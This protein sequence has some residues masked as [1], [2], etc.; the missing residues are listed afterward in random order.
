MLTIKGVEANNVILAIS[1]Y[2]IRNI[3][4]EEFYGRINKSA[5]IYCKS[6]L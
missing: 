4:W 2:V 6:M 5:S 1:N 3:Y